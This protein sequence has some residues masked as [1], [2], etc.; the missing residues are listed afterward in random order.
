VVVSQQN[1]KGQE[2]T[3][4]LV[5]TAT[6]LALGFFNNFCPLFLYWHYN[7]ALFC[8]LHFDLITTYINYFRLAPE[9]NYYNFVC[10][11]KQVLSIKDL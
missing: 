4:W 7:W 2:N 6:T 11:G 10:I 3:N 9:S 8:V 5:K 1:L